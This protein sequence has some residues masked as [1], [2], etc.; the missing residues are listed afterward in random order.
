MKGIQVNIPAK[1]PR[2]KI[3]NSGI[4]ADTGIRIMHFLPQYGVYSKDYYNHF[5]KVLRRRGMTVAYIATG[6]LV[7]VA[8]AVCHPRDTFTKKVGTKLA[9][10]A[11]LAG[12][13]VLLPVEKGVTPQNAVLRYFS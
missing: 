8:T 3:N 5:P 9:V 11:F 12:Q 10:E 13:T 2:E 6:G 7:E 4:L 1:T